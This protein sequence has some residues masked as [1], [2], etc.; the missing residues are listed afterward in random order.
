MDHMDVGGIEGEWVGWF[1]SELVI[2]NRFTPCGSEDSWVPV[3][4]PQSEVCGPYFLRVK[5]TLVE[6]DEGSPRLYVDQILEGGCTEGDCD[7][8]QFAG[9]CVDVFEACGS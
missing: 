8:E 5:G 3:G 6:N 2:D 1:S 4:L 9:E 7:T